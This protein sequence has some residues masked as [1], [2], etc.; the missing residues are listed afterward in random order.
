MYRQNAESKIDLDFGRKI[1]AGLAAAFQA[2]SGPTE[3]WPS[4]R[5]S[6]ALIG[7]RREWTGARLI[8]PSKILIQ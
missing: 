3:W 2:A 6:C 8:H 7:T 1:T 5:K 4:T